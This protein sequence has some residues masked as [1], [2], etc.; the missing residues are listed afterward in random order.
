MRGHLIPASADVPFVVWLGLNAFSSSIG[1]L[2]IWFTSGNQYPQ[3]DSNFARHSS[4]SVTLRLSCPRVSSFARLN[5]ESTQN[6]NACFLSRY[7][8]TLS[9]K[10][11]LDSTT[12]FSSSLSSKSLNNVW[13]VFHMYGYTIPIEAPHVPLGSILQIFWFQFHQGL[14]LL[15][16]SFFKHICHSRMLHPCL[17]FFLPIILTDESF[18]SL[19]AF[20]VYNPFL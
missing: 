1:N 6:S 2:N 18:V 3:L 4:Y 16:V 17:S 20:E 13:S 7:S 10:L 14:V 19:R 15:C 11:L 5:M 9:I 8:N 12:F